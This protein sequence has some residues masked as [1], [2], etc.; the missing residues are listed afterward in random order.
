MKVVAHPAA[1]D[2]NGSPYLRD[3]K[4]SLVP[5]A[6][7]KAADLLMDE[8][9][10]KIL[11][12][13]HEASALVTAF[14]A[15]TFENV[16]ELQAL[17]AQHYGASVG[18]KKG[19]IT[20]VSFDGCQKVQVQVADLLE[21]GPE[22]QSAK[23]LIDECLTEWAVGSAIELRALVNRVFQV[24]K[25][26]QINRAELFMLLRVEIQD[27]RWMR[28]MEA[29]RNSIRVIG[30]RTYVR[31]YDRPAPDAAWRPVTVDLAAA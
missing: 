23:A 24:D 10:R 15:R 14:K 12:G 6:S 2:V 29:I 4:G 17:L 25:Q 30:S 5:L 11:A 27:D 31:F 8:T 26:G 1:I 22:L 21:F 13:A 7:V 19:N 20:L 28:A 16:G 18:G 3:A 9:V